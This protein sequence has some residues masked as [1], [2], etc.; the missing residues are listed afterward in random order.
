MK[1]V[2]ILSIFLLISN[3]LIAVDIDPALRIKLQ[4]RDGS[5]A[6]KQDQLI[7]LHRD[8]SI[9][10][11]RGSGELEKALS[12]I[13]IL[14]IYSPKT[15]FPTLDSSRS[16]THC[17]PVHTGIGLQS[18]Y[19]GKGVLI[20]IIDGGFDYTHPSF[21]KPDGSLRIT[22]VW[23]QRDS[24]GTKPANFA[25]G[26][27]FSTEQSLRAKQHDTKIGSHGTLVTSMAAGSRIDGVPYYGIAPES[28]LIFVATNYQ[29]DGVMDAVEYILSEAES[30]HRPVVINM[31]LAS[32][33][34][35]HDGTSPEDKFMEQNAHRGILVTA[36]SNSGHVNQ[37]I[38]FDLTKGDTLRTFAT[39]PDQIGLL[40]FWGTKFQS[41]SL[42]LSVTNHLGEQQI[43]L[44]TIKTSTNEFD[45]TVGIGSDSIRIQAAG[46]TLNPQ[47]S[48][49]SIAVLLTSIAGNPAA[50]LDISIAITGSAGTVH[51]WNGMYRNFSDRGI[52][53]Y[54]NGNTAMTIGDG[55]GTSKGT[56]TVGSWTARREYRTESDSLIQIFGDAQVGDISF[57]SSRGPTIDNR[58]KPEIT[59]PGNELIGAYNSFDTEFNPRRTVKSYNFEQRN[60]PFAG[61][62]GTSLAAPIITGAIAL[63]LEAVPTL[64][65]QD[66]LSIF[67]ITARNDQQTTEE[68]RWGYGKIDIEA[69][70][71]YIEANPTSLQSI[72]NSTSGLSLIRTGSTIKVVDSKGISQKGTITIYSPT[73]EVITTKTISETNK[74][75]DLAKMGSGVY[76][77]TF[78]G[79][80]TNLSGK[81]FV[82]SYR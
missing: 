26:S 70:M 3:S 60:Y 81:L 25:Y 13:S 79:E 32:P 7:L 11:V 57:F 40:D 63:M 18:S 53:G 21:R 42:I 39:I 44:P 75:A 37:H 45:T 80:T 4:S 35:S 22:K 78:K 41:F 1:F 10:V 9:S 12:D 69:A 17:E 68:N 72:Q 6:D 2:K 82:P 14:T 73:G 30:Q 24:L 19:R 66:I 48:K 8:S 67:A 51:G 33:N 34:G 46:T 52:S 74:S 59:A 50:K 62:G 27:E 76:V 15:L 49:P 23:D 47:N 54:M 5:R 65:R 43:K 64:T 61:E 77:F 16:Q 58:E 71:K 29:S 55:P 38:Q 36:A 56:I 20:G 31:S 28:D